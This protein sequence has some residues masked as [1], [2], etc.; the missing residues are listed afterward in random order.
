MFL[1]RLPLYILPKTIK[2]G[3]LPFLN[4]RGLFSDKE[5]LATYIGGKIYL[6][7]KSSPIEMMKFLGLYERKK[8]KI[9][10]KKIKPNM[11]VID[12]GAHKGYFSFFTA[13][14]MKGTG[15]IYAIEPEPRNC[16]WIKK[17]ILANGYKNI[18]IH[19]IALSNLNGKTLLYKGKKSG[20]HSIKRNMGL[21]S[22]VIET[23]KLDDLL[24]ENNIQKLDFLKIDVE[25][26]EVE[27]LEGAQ[28]TLNQADLK[29]TI[30]LHKRIDREKLYNILHSNNFR[31]YKFH[32]KKA[33]IID[34]EE[35]LS[36][37]INEIYAEKSTHDRL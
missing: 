34:K 25:G 24:N 26:A 15:K 11:T 3:I 29:I 20:H 31:I 18:N 14:L 23:K 13:R 5:T 30:D 6:D 12:V 33:R 19:R 9:F 35:F 1:Y 17:G 21:G 27:V 10:K 32:K 7:F 4:N 16:F 37:N 28:H 8:T 36:Q 22:T 2:K